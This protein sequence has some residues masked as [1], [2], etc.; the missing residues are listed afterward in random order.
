MATVKSLQ[1]LCFTHITMT[2]EQFSTDVLCLLP[3]KFR[4]QL[5]H[6]IPV[7]DVCRLEED[8]LFT[9]GIDMESFWKELCGKLFLSCDESSVPIL[10]WRELFFSQFFDTIIRGDR[11]Y[12]YFHISSQGGHRIIKDQPVNEHD[13]DFVNFLVAIPLEPLSVTA[14]DTE[15]KKI[16]FFGS[17]YH[18]VHA[19][20]RHEVTLVKGPIPPGRTYH[21]SCRTNQL[22]PPRYAK[23]FPEDSCYLPDST[24]LQLITEKCRFKPK[25]VLI[26]EATFATF[27][28]NIEKECGNIDCLSGCF[29]GIESL[30]F[31]G[32]QQRMIS[33][34]AQCG[35]CKS[36]ADQALELILQSSNPVLT[37]LTV[38][39]SIKDNILESIEPVLALYGGLKTFTVISFGIASLNFSALTSIT[40]HQQL[41]RSLSISLNEVT[42][43]F[44]HYEIHFL[45]LIQTC[46]KNPSLQELKLHISPATTQ[47]V[48]QIIRVFLS[49]PCSQEQTLTFQG[50]PKS[51]P[52]RPCLNYCIAVP[53]KISMSQSQLSTSLPSTKY[54]SMS[55]PP[56]PGPV[57]SSDLPLT[58]QF[59]DAITLK[60]KCLF[61]DSCTIYDSFVDAFLKLPPLKLKRMSFQ[62]ISSFNGPKLFF[63]L[64]K[65]PLFEIESLE[66]LFSH[67]S[68]HKYIFDLLSTKKLLKFIKISCLNR[69]AQDFHDATF[70]HFEKCISDILEGK[71][72]FFSRK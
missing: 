53:L 43:I 15:R 36:V 17:Q 1:E 3:K 52:S 4:E 16:N 22:V 45:S 13:I 59:D 7:L 5:L 68:W 10:T 39:S 30:F 18:P 6:N 29:G 46:F 64:T 62:K 54:V 28:L 50:P 66:F 24:A 23:L 47:L 71:T 2:L 9:A 49:T 44:G 56:P 14:E 26:N 19:M 55:P 69:N 31:Q 72:I 40:K 25:D 27:L 42:D 48:L 58:Y 12:G 63:Q 57:K 41:L 70:E 8:S 33:S 21:E 60:Y 38:I 67:L 61:F 35:E 37:D 51:Y 34:E 32:S 20:N 11:P 65:D